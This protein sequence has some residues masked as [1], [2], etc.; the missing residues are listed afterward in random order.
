MGYVRKRQ[1]VTVTAP[2]FPGLEIQATSMTVAEWIEFTGMGDDGNVTTGNLQATCR[3]FA[4]HVVSWNL[5][6]E[7]GVPVVLPEDR[8]K[9]MGVI[10]AEDLD[11]V[12]AMSTSWLQIVS[13]VSG[14]LERTSSGMALSQSV[15]MAV[16]TLAPSPV[17]SDAPN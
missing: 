16:E 11:L 3:I 8:A 6:S 17:L 1:D 5:E 15:P 13:G 4:E 9:R 14:P 7:P 12:L 10:M 2:E